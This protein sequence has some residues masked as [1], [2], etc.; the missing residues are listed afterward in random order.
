MIFS[1]DAFAVRTHNRQVQ[2]KQTDRLPL[3]VSLE[4][5]FPAG[6]KQTLYMFP[7]YIEPVGRGNGAVGLELD[8][9]SVCLFFPDDVTVAIICH[10]NTLYKYGGAGIIASSFRSK[11]IR[12]S[13]LFQPKSFRP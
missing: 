10:G 9:A 5:L 12:Y 3:S 6:I 13:G 2:R 7:V 1:R 11:S 8:K 4:K